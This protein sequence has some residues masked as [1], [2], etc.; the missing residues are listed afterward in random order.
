MNTLATILESLPFDS[1]RSENPF[2]KEVTS[3]NGAL[4]SACTDTPE[5]ERILG[6]WLQRFQ[7]CLFGRIAAQ[8][9]LIHYC[10]LNESDIARSDEHVAEVI[11]SARSQ[12][13][14]LSFEGKA[15]GFVIL[16]VS[17]KLIA[18]APSDQLLR[19]A[20]ELGA[21]YLLQPIEPNQIYLDEAFLELPGRDSKAWKWDAGVNYFGVQADGRWWQD[22][23][24]PGGIAFS[25]NSVGHMAKT[26][27][28]NR[29]LIELYATMGV[30]GD[31]GRTSSVDSLEHSLVVAMQTI[32]RSTETLSGRATELLELPGDGG[33]LPSC[34]VELP[35][36]LMG[37]NYC[38]YS[39]WY[40]TDET[41]PAEYFLPD[42]LRPPELR[43]HS[44][45]F[46]YL[47]DSNIANPAHISMGRG[48]RIKAD[49]REDARPAQ[50]AR[51]GRM[52]PVEI[53][54]LRGRF[55]PRTRP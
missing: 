12:W 38:T 25:V 19:F 16:V 44:L 41:I 32:G 48:R 34:P 30:E 37:K 6:Q 54:I 33:Q 2:S 53:D 15:S 45:D 17:E 22:H 27:S 21:L 55:V 3:A 29:K 23:R 4:L 51:A 28:L 9:D 26:G 47:F 31:I 40:H 11:E 10:I 5:C 36:P 35:R 13:H 8:L 18:A 7:P 42:V 39:G 14:R 50:S 46:T 43:R 20:Q 49:A 24:V 1:W 52:T